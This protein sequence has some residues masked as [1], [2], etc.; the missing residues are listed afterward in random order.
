MTAKGRKGEGGNEKRRRGGKEARGR[1]EKKVFIG[2]LEGV[3]I[4]YILLRAHKRLFK[5][6]C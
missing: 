4:E 2:C 3:L 5:T 6:L 1:R